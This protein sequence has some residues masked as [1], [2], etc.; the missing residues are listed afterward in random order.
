MNKTP[1]AAAI[2]VAGVALA[3]RIDFGA[4]GKLWW[5]HVQYLASAK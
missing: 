5:A 3:A 4:E 2:M 1:L